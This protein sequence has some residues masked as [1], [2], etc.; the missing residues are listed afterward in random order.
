MIDIEK[1]IEQ[2]NKPTFYLCWTCNKP[3][4]LKNT[5]AYHRVRCDGCKV[6][7]E[8]NKQ[9]TLDEYLR[10][11]TKVMHERSLRFLEK[12][13]VRM[14]KYKDASEVVLEA[15]LN[16]PSKFASSHEM[17]AAMELIRNEVK[18]K[19]QQKIANHRVDFLIPDMKV[20]LEIDGYMHKHQKIKD[21]KRD[22]EV[23]KEL[24]EQWEVVR[25]PTKHLEYNAPKLIE[26]IVGVFK[27]KKE[28]R[29]ENNG[30]IPDW[31]SNNEKERYKSIF[32]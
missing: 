22:V 20:V 9:E 21:S 26:A 1:E 23:R 27:Y 31:Y 17:I 18:I 2:M 3:I 28:I 14:Y 19:T 16:D 32:K 6:K 10:L 13:F 8:K 12:Q 4:E 5:N 7:Y 15:A 24:G 30:L 29:K 25:I 11:K